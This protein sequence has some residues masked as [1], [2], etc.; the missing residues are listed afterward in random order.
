MVCQ[1]KG[2]N[3]GRRTYYDQFL[4]RRVV[5]LR[6][7]DE[8]AW[9]IERESLGPRPSLATACVVMSYFSIVPFSRTV[10]ADRAPGAADPVALPTAL[11]LSLLCMCAAVAAT[12]D[13]ARQENGEPSYRLPCAF[14]AA[15]SLYQTACPRAASPQSE[16]LAYEHRRGGRAPRTP[17]TPCK[18]ASLAKWSFDL[19]LSAA[20]LDRVALIMRRGV[21]VAWLEVAHSSATSNRA[22]DSA[23]VTA[24]SVAGTWRPARS[25]WT[26]STSTHAA[27]SGCRRPGRRCDLESSRRMRPASCGSLPA[28]PRRARGGR[29]LASRAIA[30]GSAAGDRSDTAAPSSCGSQARARRRGHG[31][32]G[33]P[34]QAR[35]KNADRARLR[36][37][38]DPPRPRARAPDGAPPAGA[39]ARRDSSGDG[40]HGRRRGRDRRQR[41]APG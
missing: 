37:A 34:I 41:P 19:S 26:R 21:A 16:A 32:P 6:S 33:R 40:G 10:V 22:I 13:A 9:P 28:H 27:R 1:P 14:E 20:A 4:E 38:H 15:G 31:R 39:S 29:D 35:A 17:R 3:S 18:C 23:R 11:A 12:E 25:R 8:G 7:P 24:L 30:T 2:S 36:A 5:D